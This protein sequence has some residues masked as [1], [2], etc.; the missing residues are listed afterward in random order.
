MKVGLWLSDKKA[1][2][3]NLSLL[4]QLLRQRGHELVFLDLDK[5]LEQQGPFGAIVHKVSDEIAKA[6]QGDVAASRRIR[7]F[8][9][10]SAAVHDV[11]A[12]LDALSCLPA[13][14]RYIGGHPEVVVFDPI[15][16]VRILMDRRTECSLVAASNLVNRGIVTRRF[17]L[18]ISW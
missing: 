13:A 5:S 4:E 3:L 10:A 2:K 6:D 12:S 18:G 17:A 11:P 7:A 8:E 1:K 16:G 14:Q 15:N 9:V